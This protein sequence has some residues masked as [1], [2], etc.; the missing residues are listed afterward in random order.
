MNAKKIWVRGIVQGVGFRP[1]VYVY[2]TQAHLTGWVRNTSSGVEILVQGR[3]E[4]IDHFVDKLKREP[5]T[6]ARIDS[7]EVDDCP[8][9]PSD[10]FEILTSLPQEGEFIPISPDIAICDDCRREMMDPNDR[11]YRYPFIN[12][13]NCGPRFTI[14][15]D[16][17]Y[18]RPKTTM[19]TFVM[20]DDCWHEYEDP[21][22]RRFHAQ[23]TACPECGPQVWFEAQGSILAHTEEALTMARQYLKEGKIIAVKGLGGFHLA[24][25]ASNLLAVNRLRS[26]KKRSDKPFALMAYDIDTIR[27]FCNVSEDEEKLLESPQHPI[28]LL[29]RKDETS[30][31]QGVAP[32]Q[33]TL[34]FML[35]YTP[36]HLLLLEPEPGFPKALVMTSGNVSEEPIAYKDDDALL[37]LSPLADGF[38]LHDRTIHIRVDDSVARVIKDRPFLSR[39]SR[40]YAP[41]AI[42]VIHD[43]PQLLATGPELKNTFCL[44]RDRYAFLS[45][46]IGDLENF[47]TLKSFEEGIE[48]FEKLFR[49]TPQ[50]IACDLHPDYLAT[51]YAE[52]RAAREQ[53]P[54]FKIQHHHAHLAACLGDNK[55]SSEES[56]IGVCF[57]GTGMGDDGAIWG[58]EFLVGGYQAYQRPYHLK[59]VTIPGGETAIRKPAKM[60]LAHLHSAGIAWDENLAP[61]QVLTRQES[62]VLNVQIE[63]HLNSPLTSSMGRLFDAASALLGI[64]EEIN[65][66]GQ[67]A[68]ELENALDAA[69]TDAYEFDFIDDIIDPTPLW[70]AMISD[71]KQGLST[72]KLAA[73]FHN[74]VVQM[75]NSTCQR[76][77]Q[78]TGLSTVALSGGTWQNRYLLEKTIDT[79]SAQHFTVLWHQRVPTNDGGVALGQALI[80][81]S[82]FGKSH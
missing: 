18:D 67:A 76:I 27:T 4:N 74:S 37:R 26:L 72:A 66:E 79:L 24:C 25:D 35:P 46:H 22:T 57:D 42:T 70:Q 10:T 56:V 53:L 23:P 15:K 2:A 39:R 20:C 73:R 43:L 34:G 78:Q 45:H 69:E 51:Q 9:Q 47:E 12:C 62:E 19:A 41:E 82:Q 13:T 50:A 63:R 58:G 38:L 21:T 29:S 17:P 65:Y 28:V 49:I 64:R 32:L 81:A 6:L 1:T 61:V 31:A 11:R 3:T 5:P 68:I 44:T 60:A 40:G 55:W 14:I 77:R 75:V 30:I 52:K 36:L 8:P 80:A 16:I 71:L 33:K 59:Y 7:F 48:H 54:L